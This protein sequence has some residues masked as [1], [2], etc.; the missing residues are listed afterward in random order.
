MP[1]GSLSKSLPGLQLSVTTE[2]QVS[3]ALIHY[4]TTV[5]PPAFSLPGGNYSAD[6]MTIELF[7][8]SYLA[9]IYY[10]LDG[11]EPS[12]SSTRYTGPITLVP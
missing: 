11:S 12:E 5:L 10:T 7:T 6:S 1:T 9:Q 8:P 3:G 4:G 2:I